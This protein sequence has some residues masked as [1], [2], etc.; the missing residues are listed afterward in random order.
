[1]TRHVPPDVSLVFSPLSRL[2][3]CEPERSCANSRCKVLMSATDGAISRVLA[4]SIGSSSSCG[5][6]PC[7]DKRIDR[8]RCGS[9]FRE[10]ALGGTGSRSYPV[11]LTR[12]A[13]SGFRFP[14]DRESHSSCAPAHAAG[15]VGAG[16]SASDAGL[17]GR[18]LG[19]T[20]QSMEN[21]HPSP[22]SLTAIGTT[23]CLQKVDN[24]TARASAANGLPGVK[25]CS[26]SG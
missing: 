7:W 4:L 17:P 8:L 6:F 5:C 21:Y 24:V 14:E 10:A 1:M 12:S 13:Y 3:F 18:G 2:R 19:G 11:F 23:A 15:P 26:G 20:R 25:R 9:A 16:F 22:K